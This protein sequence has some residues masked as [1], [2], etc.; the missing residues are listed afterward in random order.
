MRADGFTLVE[1]M[2]TVAIIGILAAIAVPSYN[3]YVIDSNR[4]EAQ[5]CLKQLTQAIERGHTAEMTYQ[6][7]LDGNGS[8]DATQDPDDI[9]ACASDLDDYDFEINA[10]T[11]DTFTVEAEPLGRQQASDNGG[12]DS[13]N[14][15]PL[16]LDQTG[17]EG[18]TGS[19]DADSCWDG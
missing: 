18:A 13:K 17:E 15:G 7:D 3:Q 19:G 1:L 14:C 4:A 10:L 5:S 6:T 12:S 16:T 11:A 9:V 8:T 2:I